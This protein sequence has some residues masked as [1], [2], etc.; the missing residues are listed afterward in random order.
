M[1]NEEI[2]QKIQEIVYEIKSQPFVG[3]LEE[4]QFQQI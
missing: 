4:I 2:E 3:T 1:S